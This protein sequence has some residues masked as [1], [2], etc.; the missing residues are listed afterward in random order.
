MPCE[1][2]PE[3]SKEASLVD[4]WVYGVK[5]ALQAGEVASIKALSLKCDCNCLCM[6]VKIKCGWNG[7][8]K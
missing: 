2:M 8:S 4:R 7:L 3:G 5:G 1:Q 6:S